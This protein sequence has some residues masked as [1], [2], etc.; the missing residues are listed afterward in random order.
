MKEKMLKAVGKKKVGN[1][2]DRTSTMSDFL[3]KEENHSL[4]G[5]EFSMKMGESSL[6]RKE[7]EAESNDKPSKRIKTEEGCSS[8]SNNDDLFR[9]RSTK[10]VS[11]FSHFQQSDDNPPKIMKKEK[12]CSDKKSKFEYLLDAVS[13]FSAYEEEQQKNKHDLRNN[14]SVGNEEEGHESDDALLP[15]EFQEKIEELNGSEVKFVIEKTLFST[16]V[17]PKHARLSIPPSKIAN[18]FLSETEESSLNE[19][20]KENGRLVGLPVTVLDP[21]LNEYKMCLKK[22]NMEKTCIYNL[23]KGW[24]QIVRQN[25]LELHHTLHLWSFRVSSR[26]CFAIV[27]I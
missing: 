6:K 12:G 10:R 13:L 11:H 15:R 25:H 7:K 27:K 22:W 8:R 23:T 5:E 1:G 18:K 24:N 20:I 19:S 14:E 4:Y 9:F 26:L 16:D 3:A 2:D 21:S 17:N